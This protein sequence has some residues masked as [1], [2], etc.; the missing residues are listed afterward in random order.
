MRLTFKSVQFDQSR[1][2][3]IVWVGLTQTV[4]DL[5]RKRLTSLEQWSPTFVASGVDFVEDNFSTDQWWQEWG[6]CSGGNASP[7]ER[8]MELCSLAAYLLLWGLVP[9]RGFRGLGIPALEEVGIF[10]QMAFGFELQHWLFAGT[11]GCWLI[12]Q[13]FVLASSH[14]H[15]S[16]FLKINLS[17]SISCSVYVSLSIHTHT[18][19]IGSVSLKNLG[20]YIHTFNYLQNK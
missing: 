6:G 16:Q 18:H 20:W 5:N 2:P 17:L 11:P 9:N 7:G 12:L 4:E 8:Q 13:I 15:V 10:Q 14:I 3:S 19:P 1:L